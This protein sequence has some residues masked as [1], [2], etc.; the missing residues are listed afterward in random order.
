MI[1]MDAAKPDNILSTIDEDYSI[2]Y[3]LNLSKERV[4]STVESSGMNSSSFVKNMS[5]F[6][7]IGA[8]I[9]CGIFLMVAMTTL[10]SRF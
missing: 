1:N 2:D 4:S 8:V 10:K 3:F 7:F 9:L 5:T 6:L